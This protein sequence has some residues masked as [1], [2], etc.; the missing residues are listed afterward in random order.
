MRPREQSQPTA[1]WVVNRIDL[2]LDGEELLIVLRGDLAV[3][4][5]FASDKKNPDFLKKK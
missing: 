2:I 1:P 5:T 3:I 4:L